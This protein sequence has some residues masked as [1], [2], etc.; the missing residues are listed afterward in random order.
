MKFR[1]S[2][3]Q[4]LQLM[5]PSFSHKSGKL[6]G[7]N[8]RTLRLKWAVSQYVSNSAAFNAQIARDD[9]IFLPQH[10]GLNYSQQ[11]QR[12]EG[13]REGWNNQGS[14]TRAVGRRL[15]DKGNWWDD[16]EIS[17][18]LSP[19]PTLCFYT[20]SQNIF[21]GLR[22]FSPFWRSILSLR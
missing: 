3:K 6:T 5:S 13:E 4:L 14:R 2:Q 19:P 12:S 7:S 21:Q 8:T 20:Y 11:C 17:C 15:G 22:V 1:W 18:N 16:S 9:F 10:D